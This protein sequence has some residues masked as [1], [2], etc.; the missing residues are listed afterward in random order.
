MG[1]NLILKFILSIVII[2]VA[3]KPKEIKEVSKFLIFFYLTSFTFGGAAL[4]VIYMVNT[5]K[6]SIQNGVIVGNYTL[7]TIFIG[8]IIAL[9]VVIGAF[10]FVKLKISKKDLFCNITVKI[11]QK[12]IK[13]RAMIDT[14]NLLKEPITNIPVIVME[15][16]I[17]CKAVP[18]EILENIDNILGGDL[19][20]IQENTKQ[21]YMSKLKVIPFS[22]LGKQNGMLLGLRA[23]GLEI[24]VED[25]IKKVDKIIVGIY[26]KKLSK[27]GEYSALL[28]I[29]VI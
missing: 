27:K 4:G 10:K 18:K 19:S 16:E 12:N 2:Y 29:D 28:G 21:E 5:G 17:L 11:N 25:G 23:D 15:H 6:I 1:L 13:T 7:K 26:N 9:I 3:F 20:S 24:E 14:G 8:I 22:S